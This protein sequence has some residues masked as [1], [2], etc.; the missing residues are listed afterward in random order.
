MIS[1]KYLRNRIRRAV[2]E[3]LL[4]KY[5]E[6]AFCPVMLLDLIKSVGVSR[7]VVI[8]HLRYLESSGFIKI[9]WNLSE[10]AL[11]RLETKG[12]DIAEDD[13]LLDKMFPI[14]GNNN[15]ILSNGGKR[16]IELI[17]YDENIKLKDK[18]DCIEVAKELY[19]DINK[20]HDMGID[21]NRLYKLFTF[22]KIKLPQLDKEFENSLKADSRESLKV[23]KKKD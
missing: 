3:F 12:I 20:I 18:I 13:E 17:E 1:K 4:L 19:S 11:I 6:D 5:E 14:S 9:S 23:W 7:E 22:L 15:L 8:S 10:T 2:L 21:F 16:I